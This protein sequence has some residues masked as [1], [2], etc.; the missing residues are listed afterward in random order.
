MAGVMS[1]EDFYAI[2]DHMP[3]A[4]GALRVGG[5]LVFRTGGWSAQL[6][7]H[8]KQRPTG[9]NPFILYVDLI[10]TPPPTGSAVPQVLTP[11]E[12]PELRL[13]N[14]SLEYQEVQFKVVGADEEP[15]EKLEVQ[16][17]K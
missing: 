12:L 9:I 10:I 13:E 2:H 17:P 4:D 7:L 8:E 5:T 14:V 11:V 1:Y 6:R 16:H 15:P 3:G